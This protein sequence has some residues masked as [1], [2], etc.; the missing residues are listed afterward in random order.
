MRLVLPNGWG[1]SLS[2]KLGDEFDVD[3][4]M[5]TGFPNDGSDWTCVFH[6]D[7]MKYES[8]IMIAEEHDGE[9]GEIIEGLAKLSRR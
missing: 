7:V 1:V 8:R 3:T 6:P 2:S 5:V 9:I 4:S